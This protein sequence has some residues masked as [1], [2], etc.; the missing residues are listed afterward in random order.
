MSRGNRVVIN[1]ALQTAETVPIAGWKNFPRK[2][3]SLNH[4]VEL[5]Q[6]ETITPERVR[7]AGAPIAAT[8]TG[9]IEVELIGAVYDDYI[10]AAACNE[11]VANVLTM[12]GDVAKPFAIE[13]TY[14]D[15]NQHHIWTG[16]RVNTFKLDIP[17]KG[18]LTMTFGWMGSG[19]K[20]A[21]LPFSKTPAVTKLEPK[22]TSLNITDVKIDGATLKGRSCVTAFSFEINNNITVQQCLFS[23]L[24]GGKVEEMMADMNGAFTLAYNRVAQEVLDKQLTGATVAIEALITLVDGSTY[25][26]KIPKAQIGGDLPAGGSDRLNASLTYTVVSDGTVASLPTLTRTVT[27]P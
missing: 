19:Y 27:L 2:S 12:G 24:Y 15:D 18:L 17:E 13:K 14:R 6:S 10:A 11:W 16:M 25:L 3:D 5:V 20:N 8:A 9:D 21:I 1:A 7:S 22:A 4:G 23:G 26:L